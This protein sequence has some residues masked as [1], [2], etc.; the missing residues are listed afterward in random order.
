[1]CEFL[2]ARGISRFKLP[3]HL[4]LSSGLPRTPSGKIQKVLLK[5]QLA[6]THPQPPRQG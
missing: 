2:S 5:Q 3:E 4:V 6:D 1:L